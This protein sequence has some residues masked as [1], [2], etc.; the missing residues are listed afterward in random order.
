MLLA[1]SGLSEALD[2]AI[3]HRLFMHMNEHIQTIK[4]LVISL[5]L[6]LILSSVAKAQQSVDDTRLFDTFE[7]A[8]WEEAMA[9]LD[10]FA[11]QL[12]REPSATGVILVYGGQHRQ[13]GEPQAWSNCLRDYLVNRR[14]ISAGRIV[15]IDGGYRESLT[16]EMWTTFRKGYRPL[17]QP[18]PTIKAKDVR[19]TKGKIK[20]WRR[21]CN[22]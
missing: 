16:A 15:M 17:I 18:T 1:R 20:K 2:A 14:G 7:G 8:N 11:I 12:Q 13:R 21:L 10:N 19:Y 5:G 22:I 4:K 9:R 6:V 3:I